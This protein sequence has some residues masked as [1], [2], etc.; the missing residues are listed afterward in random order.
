MSFSP[1]R[2]ISFQKTAFSILNDQTTQNR[3]ILLH[4]LTCTICTILW[5]INVTASV[6]RRQSLS[7]T[8]S[9]ASTRK[10][11]VR[12]TV[13]PKKVP[14]PPPLTRLDKLPH[15]RR[16]TLGVELMQ[17]AHKRRATLGVELMQ[18]ANFETALKFT[19]FMKFVPTPGF[20][21]PRKK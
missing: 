14:P 12:T 20:K 8:F 7:H 10:K 5:K 2:V 16:A 3:E 17:K 11:K 21:T 9:F 18:E 13:F 6:R 19:E 1:W 15:K 4:S